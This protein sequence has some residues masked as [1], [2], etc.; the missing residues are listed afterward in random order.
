VLDRLIERGEGGIRI[1]PLGGNRAGEIAIGRFLHNPRV[2][3]AEM[4]ARAASRTAEVAR[5]RPVLVIQDT[6]SLRDDGDQN[7]LQLHPSIV[8]DADDGSLLGLAHATFLHRSGGKKALHQKRPF[9]EKESRRWLD[10]TRAA[11]ELLRG[12][13]ASITVV[14]DREADIYEEFAF[15]PAGIDLVIRVAQDRKLSAT[16]SL[17]AC[18]DMVPELGRETI[19]LPAGPGRAAREAVLV[20]KA[21]SVAVP[22]ARRRGGAKA[23]EL[24]AKVE[25]TFVEARELNPPAGAK[26]AHWRLLTTHPVTNLAQALRVTGFYRQRWTIEQLFRTMKTKGFDIEAVRMADTDAFENLAVATLIAAVKVLQMV[27]DRDGTA[28]RPI[29]DIIEIENQSAIEAISQSLEGKT[30]RQKNPHPKGSLAYAAW[31]CGRLGGWTGYYGKPGPVVMFQGMIRL[32]T[33]ITGWKL[34]KLV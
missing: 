23:G 10:A 31:V 13:A 18:L 33:L 2:R 6:T 16:T 15:R 20:L 26:P 28:N 17:F 29:S 27:R 4:V 1:R 7:S 24:P 5:G 32:H 9:E 22:R 19:T 14:A 34:A 30:E 25:L 21:R 12:T 11:G 8:V 3:P